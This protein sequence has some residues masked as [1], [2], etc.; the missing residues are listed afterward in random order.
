[1]PNAKD[2]LDA[3]KASREPDQYLGDNSERR[4]EAEHK[5]DKA[6]ASAPEPSKDEIRSL[7]Q[8]LEEQ[9]ALIAGLIARDKDRPMPA[10]AR[11]VA[12]FEAQRARFARYEM[13][14][15]DYEGLVTMMIH[16]HQDLNQNW[17][18]P[19]TI[20]GKKLE[21]QRGKQY[22]VDVSVLEVLDNAR[23]Q[24]VTK[25]IDAEG[26]PRTQVIDQLSYP[27]SVIAMGRGM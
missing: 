20:N 19:V 1:M 21:L 3:A 27:Y 14:R 7:K 8:Q 23:M 2:I 22:T 26:N 16:T 17:D 13:I 10:V 11:E 4:Q 18:V 9:A 15:R 25:V 24:S 12:E 6:A 5:L